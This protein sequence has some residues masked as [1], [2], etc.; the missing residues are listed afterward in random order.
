VGQLS[1]RISFKIRLLFTNVDSL[2]YVLLVSGKEE[3]L[4]H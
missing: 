1:N 4:W 2:K 3:S